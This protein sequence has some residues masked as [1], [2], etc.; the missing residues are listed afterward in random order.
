ME[1]EETKKE[2]LLKE[3]NILKLNLTSKIDKFSSA[4]NK[5]MMETQKS[6]NALTAK[7]EGN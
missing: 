1:I 4:K 7:E 2:T 3:V 6:Q 5:M